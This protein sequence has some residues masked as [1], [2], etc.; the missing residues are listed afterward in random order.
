MAT[1]NRSYLLIVQAML[2]VVV[3]AHSGSRCQAEQPLQAAGTPARQVTSYLEKGKVELDNKKYANAIKPLSTAIRL[4]PAAGDAYR[5]RGI[6]FDRL[7]MSKKA[8]EDFTKYVTLRPNDPQGYILRGD[9]K[10][11][12]MEHE[13]ALDDYNS[14]IRKAPSLSAAYVGRGLAYAGLGQYSL[15]IKDYQW[16]LA[17]DPANA[18]ATESLAMACMQAGRQMEAMSYFEKALLLEIDP[19]MRGRIE[20]W[21]ENLSQGVAASNGKSASGHSDQ[22]T[23]KPLW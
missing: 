16:V 4:D 18:D 19:S 1:G 7:G 21:I 12:S 13:S 11:F 5:L 17:K 2:F 8:L 15:A 23:S 10:N 3:I 6:A 14:A 22:Q 20:K 9:A